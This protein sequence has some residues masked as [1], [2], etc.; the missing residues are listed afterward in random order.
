MVEK[1]MIIKLK[2]KI[3][4]ILLVKIIIIQTIRTID[5]ANRTLIKIKLKKRTMDKINIF[6]KNPIKEITIIIKT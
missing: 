6:N 2:L 1:I 4:I 5:N 3:K